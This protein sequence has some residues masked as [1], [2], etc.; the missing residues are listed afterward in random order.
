[1]IDG[2][3]FIR[4][5]YPAISNS[6]DP[7]IYRHLY[8][9][10]ILWCPP[11]LPDKTG[12]D[13]VAFCYGMKDYHIYVELLEIEGLSGDDFSYVT[14]LVQVDTLTKSG[15]FIERIVLRGSWVVVSYEG[16]PCIRYQVWNQK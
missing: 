5:N 11:S 1:M 12:V 2:V 3:A 7:T 9:P 6:N 13:M 4:D 10:D 8:H 16:K 14:G 15:E